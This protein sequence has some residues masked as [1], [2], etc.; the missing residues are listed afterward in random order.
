MERSPSLNESDYI[1][2]MFTNSPI[3]KLIK[4]H[5]QQQDYDVYSKA[6]LLIGMCMDHRK[7]LKIPEKFAYIMRSGGANFRFNEFH[8]SFALAMGHIKHFALI[9]HT[10][11]GM[12]NL[13]SKKDQIINGLVDVAGWQKEDAE[14]HVEES[15]AQFEIRHEVEFTLNETR[16]FRKKYPTIVVAPLI[17]RVEDNTL[18]FIRED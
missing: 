18:Y 6:E 15:L 12:V 7:T 10:Q 2:K 1:P 13:D 4:Y 14:K 16:R 3:E 9:G 5:N 8:I 11:C 17:Y